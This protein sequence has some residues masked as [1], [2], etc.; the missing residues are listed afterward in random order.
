MSV[1]VNNKNCRLGWV[2]EE[3]RRIIGELDTNMYQV[4]DGNF[5]LTT[6]VFQRSYV[7]C[8]ISHRNRK[9]YITCL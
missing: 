2:T 3:I 4:I 5:E 1:F 6:N 8:F 9:M 7:R